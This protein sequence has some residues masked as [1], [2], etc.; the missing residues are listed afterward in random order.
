[1]LRWMVDAVDHDE[2]ERA[3]NRFELEPEL[4]LDGGKDSASYVATRAAPAVRSRVELRE[5]KIEIEAASQTCPVHDRASGK[6][7]QHACERVTTTVVKWQEESLGPFMLRWR[8][9]YCAAAVLS[10]GHTPKVVRVRAFYVA[11]ALAAVA[12]VFLGFAR[13]YYLRPRF[14]EGPLPLYLQVH[15]AVFSAW[16]VLFVA[17]T[18]LV[19]AHRTDLHRRLGWVGAALAAVMIVAALTAAILSGRRAI[20][21]GHEREALTFFATPI[22]SMA[23]FLGLV[24]AAIGYR[25]RS[26]TH[27]RLML[28]ATISILDAATARWPI[29]IVAT[30]SWA[31]YVLDDLL[32]VAAAAYDLVSRRRVHPAYIWGGLLVVGAQF[33]RP[34]VGATAAWQTFARAILE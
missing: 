8:V 15:G 26:E 19:A 24:A 17:Q 30:T 5:S 2:L 11:M 34:I 7:R 18:S 27:K 6:Q 13:T 4:F 3:S 29:A 21:A 12:A 33:L 1:M 28:L 31:Y 22:S 14:Q 32:I 23:V 10:L 25:H 20:D 16:I 9:I